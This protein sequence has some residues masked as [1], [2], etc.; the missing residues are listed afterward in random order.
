[1]NKR[2]AIFSVFILFCST[3]LPDDYLNLTQ[4]NRN[5]AF[6]R[7]FDYA[8]SNFKRVIKNDSSELNILMAMK[9]SGL[10]SKSYRD[11]LLSFLAQN[12]FFAD[13]VDQQIESFAKKRLNNALLFP[14]F[15]APVDAKID[16]KTT[17]SRIDEIKIRWN[18][19][20]T[21]LLGG[22]LEILLETKIG[23]PWSY[24]IVLEKIKNQIDLAQKV[25]SKDRNLLM[26]S[27]LY[28]KAKKR[29]EK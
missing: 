11:A 9:I 1:M 7:A 20:R 14:D 23:C 12:I 22:F 24:K 4:K 19:L 28:Q 15:D 16:G 8:L 26:A 25:N 6:I 5:E 18:E 13:S 2:L 29:L 10:I 3:I 17:A 21:K 27:I